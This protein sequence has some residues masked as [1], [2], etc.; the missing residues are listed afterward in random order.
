MLQV[1]LDIFLPIG[2]DEAVESDENDR[3]SEHAEREAN[4]RQLEKRYMSDSRSNL[5]E[6]RQQH[7]L[8]LPPVPPMPFPSQESSS[9]YGSVPPSPAPTHHHIGSSPAQSSPQTVR[10]SPQLVQSS[11]EAV[12]STPQSRRSI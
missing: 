1:T 2:H 4:R 6:V 7:E 9:S 3:L 11:P 12:R 5:N 10:S 8:N